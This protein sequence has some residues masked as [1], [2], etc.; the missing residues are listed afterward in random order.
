MFFLL[1]AFRGHSTV[2]RDA[3]DRVVKQ[4]NHAPPLRYARSDDLDSMRALPR[5]FLYESVGPKKY[6]IVRRLKSELKR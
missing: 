1:C 2:W 6:R 3:S 5:D 4:V